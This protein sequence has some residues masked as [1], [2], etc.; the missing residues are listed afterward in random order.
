G[1]TW[2]IDIDLKAFF[3][4][5]N[6]D[7]LIYRIREQTKD[8]GLLRLIGKILKAGVIW[9]VGTRVPWE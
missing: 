2:V 5:V 4:N 8:K 1:K 3:D 9:S 6:H 7:L